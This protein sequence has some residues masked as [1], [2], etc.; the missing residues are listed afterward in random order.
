[1]NS[2][3]PVDVWSI[4]KYGVEK[5]YK[6]FKGMPV[7]ELEKSAIY[8]DLLYLYDDIILNQSAQNRDIMIV[9]YK[10]ILECNMILYSILT[11]QNIDNE[12]NHILFDHLNRT[13]YGNY[14]NNYHKSFLNLDKPNPNN[15]EIL[16]NKIKTF[17]RRYKY[18]Q[19]DTIYTHNKASNNYL[20]FKYI[21][22][23]LLQYAKSNGRSVYFIEP[24]RFRKK[25]NWGYDYQLI[26][27][28]AEIVFRVAK[29]HNIILSVRNQKYVKGLIQSSVTI[30]S[31][32]VFMF[33]K[34]LAKIP[35]TTILIPAF[36]RIDTRALCVA[37]RNTGHEVV[38]STHG[39][40]IGFY[41]HNSWYYID[42]VMCDKYL[43]PTK[44]SARAM[45]KYI[46]SQKLSKIYLP[47]IITQRENNLLGR[48]EY[49]RNF[50]IDSVANTIMVVEFPN[51]PV[52]FPQPGETGLVH[53]WSNIKLAEIIRN[54]GYK[55]IIKIHPDRIEESTGLY[56][57]YYDEIITNPF[58]ESFKVAGTFIFTGITSTTFPFA[59]MTNRRI[60]TFST[61]IKEFIS[62]EYLSDIKSRVDIIPSTFK[63]GQ[64]VFDEDALIDM[65][66]A[67]HEKINNNIVEKFYFD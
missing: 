23:P 7:T 60:L 45:G 43:M 50:E 9:L 20:A 34:Y 15:R 28:L 40:N 56:E 58:E 54:S 53:I 33:T 13:F 42:N 8:N 49:L 21:N 62:S 26:D 55:A 63:N 51:T 25:H 16:F 24:Y 2:N 35:Q 65:L 18:H 12:S 37:G 5:W 10:L 64:F 27:S 41:K 66:T 30:A 52:L 29:K 47:K 38:G 61:A 32:K 48:F 67:K 36:G 6:N 17:A 3:I 39:G 1:M 31:D 57:K 46:K 22:V 19:L 11:Q 59:L 4:K 14:I 44:S